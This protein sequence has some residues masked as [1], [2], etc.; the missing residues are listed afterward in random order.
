MEEQF[1]KDTIIKWTSKYNNGTKNE[2]RQKENDIKNKRIINKLL[3]YMDKIKVQAKERKWAEKPRL[4]HDP[5]KKTKELRL[6]Q[7]KENKLKTQN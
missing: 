7:N 5:R 1:P 2:A 3:K 6:K 4:K